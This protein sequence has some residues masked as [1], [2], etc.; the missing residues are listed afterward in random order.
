METKKMRYGQDEIE[1]P[2]KEIASNS[3]TLYFEAI[4]IGGLVAK[5][6]TSCKNI[7]DIL[8]SGLT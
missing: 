2:K 7:R 6:R 1:V 5:G 3:M 4:E 8:E